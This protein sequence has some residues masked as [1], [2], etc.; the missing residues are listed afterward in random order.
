MTYLSEKVS[1]KTKKALSPKT[2]R[3]TV[4]DIHAFFVWAEGR[5][6]I[7]VN[8]FHLVSSTILEKKVGR[9]NKREWSPEEIKRFLDVSQSDP[10]IVA[11]FALALFTGMRGRELANI[12]ADSPSEKFL[13]VDAGKNKSS[14]RQVPVHPI[15]QPLVTKLRNDAGA[16]G[17]LI[18]GLTVSQPD[19]NRYKNIGKKIKRLRAKANISE[20]VDFHSTRRSVAGALERAGVSQDMAARILGH[21]PTSLTYGLYSGGLKQDQLLEAVKSIHYGDG[22]E[23]SLREVIT[24]TFGVCYDL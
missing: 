11:M 16:D 21:T 14:V 2:I 18:P 13:W 6:F 23:G 5:G 7:E 8:P 9:K 1:K 15:I 3:D 24:N 20:E 12:K 17:Y 22:V 10:R 19:N 4:S